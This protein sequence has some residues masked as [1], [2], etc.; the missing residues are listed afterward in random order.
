MTTIR[1]PWYLAAV[2]LLLALSAGA[3][4]TSWKQVPIPPLPPFTAAQPRR[5][6]L[7]NGMVLFLQEDHELPLI[8]AIARIRGGSRREPANKTGLVDLY[9]QVW[10]TGGTTQRTGDQLDD[11][12]EARAAKVETGGTADSTTIGFSCLKEDLNDVFNVFVEVMR[13]PAFRQD[14][15]D[16]A[17]RQ[18]D[19]AISRRNDD[20]DE[21]V[22]RESVKLAYGPENPYARNPEYASIAAIT[23]ED[24]VQWHEQFLHPNNI[25]LGVV[26]DF[27]SAQ[28]EARLRQ[29]FA[30]WP[31]G[32]PE[33]RPEIEFHPANP[34]YYLVA[35]NDVDQSSVRMVTLGITRKNPDYFAASL[36]NEAFAGGFSSRLIS[37]IRTRQGLAYSVGGGIGASYDH[38][39][40]LTIGLGTKST[41]TL[42]AIRALEK[43]LAELRTNPITEQELKRARDAILNSFVFNFDSPG[44]VLR[45]RMAYEF[46]GYPLDFLERYRAAIEK[47]TTADLA[48]VAAKYIHSGQMAVLVVGNTKEFGQPLST[49][50]AVTPIDISIPG[51]PAG[52][53]AA[54]GAA[55][56]SRPAASNAE[57]KAL[58]AKVVDALGG[59]AKVQAVRALREKMNQQADTPRGQVRYQ[60]ETTIA[61]PDRLRASLQQG[62]QSM[63]LVFTPDAAF[64][65]GPDGVQS[66]PESQ[67]QE[68]LDQL[69]RDPVFVAQH[70]SDPKF[71]FTAAG[72]QKVQDV[73][74]R[75]LDVGAD[76]VP[77]RYYVDPGTGRILRQQYRGVGPGGPFEGETDLSDWKDMGGITM[78]AHRV[79]KQNGKPSSIVDVLE[80]QVNPPIDSKLF[81]RP[82]K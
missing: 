55:P 67:K 38:P 2:V 69:K 68:S 59:P 24:L 30:S 74:A 7:P 6:Q 48:R 71:T 33:P 11:F 81:E 63:T 73:E 64:M 23:R 22:S 14:K 56:P 80:L 21:I 75:V 65:I 4:V 17:K 31:A 32:P 36:F 41:N 15:L 8:D 20:V 57:G 26:G 70:L 3:Q 18:E 10:R 1:R 76:G 66:V 34:G 40:M 50:G 28:M 79:N 29:A 54:A 72:T 19:T 9:G 53:P 13:Q 47:V 77:V 52:A 43:E 58:M 25:I 16:L 78:A 46:Y 12:L 60:V 37:D 42:Q 49:L 39:G 62:G 61:F 44:K 5:V 45:E 27:D 51:S 35:K 82:A